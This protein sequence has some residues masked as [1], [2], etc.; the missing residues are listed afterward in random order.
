MKVS[1]FTS[2]LLLFLVIIA[3]ISAKESVE[4]TLK[5]GYNKVKEESKKVPRHLMKAGQKI[6]NFFSSLG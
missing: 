3:T 6:Q 4:N 1:L 2:F 5:D